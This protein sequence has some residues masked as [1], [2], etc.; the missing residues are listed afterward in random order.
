MD[1]SKHKQTSVQHV[2]EP[3]TQRP[4]RAQALM[5]PILQILC[6]LSKPR[7]KVV[8]ARAVILY[9]VQFNKES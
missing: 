1:L 2:F 5:Q 8:S 9:I 7:A 6:R 3:R 4:L